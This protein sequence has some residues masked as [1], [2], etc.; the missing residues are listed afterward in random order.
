MK[1]LKPALG[2]LFLS[3]LAFYPGIAQ[4]I[5]YTAPGGLTI[6][7]GAGTSYQRSDLAN[8]KGY[9]LD[10]TLGSPLYR[11]ANAFLAVDWKFR[12]LAGENKAFDHRI[13]ADNTYSNIRYSF[14]SY[15]LEVGLTLNRL[16]ERTGIVLTGF[17]GAGITHGRTFTDLYDAG[18][19]LYDFGSIDP[20]RDS[21]LV[22]KD[23]VS[24]SDG[25]FETALV[26]KAALLPTAGLFFGYQFSRA[27]TVGIVYKTNFYLTEKNSF[28]GIDLDNRILDGSPM[29]RNNYISLGL[30]WRIRGG[31]RMSGGSY[32]PDIT[33]QYTQATGTGSGVVTTSLTG[34]T[35]RITEPSADPYQT[36]LTALNIK[37]TIEH[38]GGPENVRFF[39]NGF[40][41][42]LFTFNENTHAFMANVRLREGENRFRI[43]ASNQVSTAQDEVL[44]VMNPPEV[45]NPGPFV[46]F[47]SPWRSRIAS[48][49]DRLDL[50]ASV[51]Y[52]GSK[53]DVRLTLNGSI[54]PFDFDPVSGQVSTSVMLT[55]G[56]NQLL[57]KGSNE[58]GTA[59]DR[60][61][62]EFS[63]PERSVLPA[64]RFINPDVPVEVESS[65]FPLSAE[66]LN[67]RGR[68]EVS[69]TFNGTP[70]H[71][72]SF[73]TDGLLSVGLFLP[74]GVN[75]IE[76]TAAN[77]AGSA[78]ETTYI[79]YQEPVYYVPVYQEPVYQDPVQQ[80]P[81]Y[82]E[83]VETAAP[84]LIRILSP[85][86]QSFRTRGSSGDLRAIVE[87][88]PS[89]EN[90]ILNFNGT[91][92]RDFTFDRRTME[93]TTRVALN[94]GQN[95]LTIHAQNASGSTMV[96]QVFIREDAPCTQPA[97]RL[98]A[99]T[100]GQGESTR[101]T[102]QLQA[103]VRNISGSSELS[104]T[105][106]GKAVPFTYQ[107]NRVSSSV[108]LASGLNTLS[109]SAMNDCGEVSSSARINYKPTE[110]IV[111][112]TAPAVTFTVSEVNRTD[113]SHEL[114]GSVRGVIN[115]TG[116]SLTL[117]GRAY[118]GFQFVPS[119]GALTAK[120]KLD[121]GTHSILV[122]AN[123]ECG[124]DQQNASVTLE[125]PCLAPSVAFSISEV[126]RSD[127]SHELRGSVTGVKN[128]SG[129]SVTLDGRAYS[130][131]QFVPSTGNLS[132]KFKL[133]PGSH[134]IVVRANNECGT[135]SGT[136]SVSVSKP[137]E[138][139]E[140]EEAA[141]GIRINPGNADW[142]FCLV[143]PS[144]TFSRDNLT[145]SGFSY[146]GRASSLYIMPIGGGGEATVNGRPYAIR[147]GQY[148]LFTGNL[149]VSV[150][151]NNPGAMGQWSVCITSNRA[152][153][154]GNGN[155]RPKSPCEAEN[156]GVSR[157][158]RSR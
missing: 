92:T 97:I 17:A 117:D 130:G 76:I 91:S 10:F 8:S 35:V 149:N 104:L 68:N 105:V 84:P 77:E 18:N 56:D 28:A 100:G 86:R 26:N 62:V 66:I 60:L 93:L 150:S 110:E 152:P 81:V 134:S 87:N 44:I 29:D 65:R 148:Y 107:N 131:F 64:V 72:F 54:T 50:T 128:K 124:T 139:E 5:N 120:F 85:V 80:D 75:I 111:P 70:V 46:E 36:E 59:E 40:P 58:M 123:N 157:G 2:L 141:C 95:I 51:K 119:T 67:I 144:G 156:A 20:N 155:N 1:A 145:N 102:Y 133:D 69:M 7:L 158:N 147:S 116:I 24:L 21:K 38:V 108:P 154:S 39:Q 82:T 137:A 27:I 14:F 25:D 90:L 136:E 122:S 47:T 143:T 53:E 88:V 96:D 114:R 63:I 48:S 9:G 73:S 52:V 32:S 127:A 22:Y 146:S 11:R 129:I 71:N 3:M 113:A 16:R 121:P 57:I 132:A 41:V 31:G 153:V 89:K 79:T 138:P 74:A 4:Q 142:Q 34:P 135:D 101:Q 12:F 49:S 126:N 98:I 115:K 6:G 19:N 99:P 33:N 83:P 103:E 43:E 151:T 94:E 55:E 13:N 23:L 42:N 30:R 78:T 140:P 45:A 125:E 37:A 118:N 112:C 15:D 61:T 109:L 106:N